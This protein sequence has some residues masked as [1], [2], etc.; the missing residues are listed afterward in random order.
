MYEDR[1][2]SSRYCL[3][4]CIYKVYMLT[5]IQDGH[6]PDFSKLQIF[7]CSGKKIRRLLPTAMLNFPWEK[8]G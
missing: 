5:K 6:S 4:R 7:F 8:N 1:S 2:R 3:S